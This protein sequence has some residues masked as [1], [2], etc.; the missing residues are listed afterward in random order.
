[1]ILD[2]TVSP[3]IEREDRLGTQQRLRH[4]LDYIEYPVCDPSLVRRMALA[5]T[6][7]DL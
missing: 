5:R 6:I 2:S 4:G 1:M 3:W 7:R